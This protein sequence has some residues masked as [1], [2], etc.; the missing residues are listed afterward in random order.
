MLLKKTLFLLLIS[1]F[2]VADLKAQAE[3]T[4][5]GNGIE[6]THEDT[7]PSVT[8]DTDYGD[9]GITTQTITKEYTIVN[10]GSSNLQING[11][12]T[13]SDDQ[14]E[15]TQPIL[16]IIPPGGSTT[17]K[18]IYNP[19]STG[20]HV[21]TI[22]IP[23]N[24]P[25]ENPYTFSIAG[26][27]ASLIDNDGD[28]IMDDVDLDDDNDGILDV[29]EMNTCVSD[30]NSIFFEDFG[31]GEKTSTPYT[32]YCYEDGTGSGCWTGAIPLMVN[33][34]EYAIVQH[35]RPDASNFPDWTDQGDHT[36][37]VNGRM[38]VVNASINPNEEFYRRTIDIEPNLNIT[39]NLWL[40]DLIMSGSSIRPNVKFK[41]ETLDG[42]Q[43]GSAINTGNIPRNNKWNDYSLSLNPGSNTKVQIVLSNNASGGGGNDLALDDIN[44]L[45]YF[46]DSDDD[47]IAD[48]QDTDS[49]DDG[50][51]DAIEGDGTYGSNDIDNDDVLT[52]NVDAN[53]IALIANGTGQG[54]GISLDPTQ[55]A[56]IRDGGVTKTD[57]SEGYIPGLTTVYTIVAKN[58]GDIFI[59]DAI[60]SDP[61]P[62][63]ISSGDITWTATAHGSA[64]TQAVGTMNGALQDTIDIPLNDS[65]VYLVSVEVPISR[66]GDL[67][68]TVTITLDFETDS[69]DN[70]ATDI[71]V[72]DACSTVTD[73]VSLMITN[74]PTACL[75]NIV[76]I[77]DP[78][79]TAGSLN[80]GTNEYYTNSTAT[81]L[82]SAPENTIPGTY[83]IVSTNSFGC[84]DTAEITFGNHPNPV[85]ELQENISFCEDEN[86][87]IDAGDFT[88]WAWSNNENGRTITVN[89]AGIYKVIVSNIHN[90]L[91]S[92]SV[93]V[94]V[95][96]KPIIDLGSDSYLC[97]GDSLTLDAGDYVLEIWN[98]TDTSDTYTV[99]NAATV[100]VV[101]ID[102]NGCSGIG[103]IDVI[104]RL[105]PTPINITQADDSICDL[106]GEATI[107]T[108]TNPEGLDIYWSTNETGESITVSQTGQFI[109]TKTNEFSCSVQDSLTVHQSCEEVEITLPTIFTPNGDGTNET[110]TP[111][112]DPIQLLTY[113]TQVNYIVYNRWGRVM[114]ASENILPNW[115]GKSQISGKDCP[116][117]VYYWIL[118]YKT[119]QGEEKANNG[120]S[121]LVR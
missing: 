49:D 11:S 85:V 109:A 47:G 2:T 75:P 36:G 69:T 78:T 15:I 81:N 37:D 24:D 92:D 32:N 10:D 26:N 71:N 12:I 58:N 25:N 50:C 72:N 8:D 61:L 62:A 18:V 70:T 88:S 74:P 35:A 65:V 66:T 56:C 27:G 4:L 63:G 7:S 117:G 82:H 90:C 121:H 83:Y 45:Q 29:D 60:V 20:N 13:S 89:E 76:N 105:S 94:T 41:L 1:F 95:N 51:P 73:S 97:E 44:V 87:T 111:I 104:Q 55:N 31:A 54:L 21:A 14:F 33:D 3:I 67:V 114:Y 40:L 106:I 57:N 79:W 52:G 38:M 108:V 6:I 80:M 64:T 16:T 107:L 28:G 19:K 100:S 17:F 98:N 30:S 103:A 5:Y 22:S 101:V 59:H 120:F 115:N 43:I 116:D 84:A 68:N 110:L 86:V 42:I 112:E 118:K 39:I 46:C 77:T 96:A 91:D 34:G 102:N 93:E 119:I 113:T 9:A 99:N 48:Y 53:G 23:N